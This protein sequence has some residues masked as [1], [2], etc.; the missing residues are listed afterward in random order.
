MSCLSRPGSQEQL[1][2]EENNLKGRIDFTPFDLTKIP[3]N[4]SVGYTL[5]SSLG[6]SPEMVVEMM[7]E[8]TLTSRQDECDFDQ[9]QMK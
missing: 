8:L 2:G 5:R 7:Y 6:S 4:P 9:S 3:N 1:K